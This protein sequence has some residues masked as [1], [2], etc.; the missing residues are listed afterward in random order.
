LQQAPYGSSL[1]SDL[2]VSDKPAAELSKTGKRRVLR[3]ERR[4]YLENQLASSGMKRVVVATA[5]GPGGGEGGGEG[6][7]LTHSLPPSPTLKNSF[8]GAK[9]KK[10]KFP[11]RK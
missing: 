3:V 11:A 2:P 9:R 7:S 10:G 1:A 6:G 8:Q 5:V 4:T